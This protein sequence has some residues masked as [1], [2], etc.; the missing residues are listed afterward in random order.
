M[1]LNEFEML[2]ELAFR[3]RCGRFGGMTLEGGKS[4]GSPPPPDP[5]IAAAQKS[6]NAVTDQAWSNYQNVQAPAIQNAVN[7]Q[8]T[9]INNYANAMN[10]SAANQNAIAAQ[11]TG[12]YNNV[13]LPALQ[14]LQTA[15]NNYNTP[16]YQEE[17][18][19]SA[20][21][22][23]NQ[24]YAQQLKNTQ[25]Q[26]QAYGINPNSGAAQMAGNANAIQEASAGAAAATQARQQAINLGLNMQ[27][28]VFADANP[29]LANA[30]TAAQTAAGMQNSGLQAQQTNVNNV[31]NQSTLA[32]AA[33]QTATGGYGQSGQ[34]GVS[35]YNAQ[36]AAYNAQQQANA[37]A[38]AGL[39]GAIG[40][41]VGLYAGGAFGAGVGGAAAKAG[42]G[43]S[44]I[45]AKENIEFIGT[46][47]DGLNVYEFEYKPE[48][49]DD[50]M[51]G[52]GRFRG[53]MAHEVE[54]VY[55]HAVFTMDSGYKAVN[56]A[57][58]ANHG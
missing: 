7:T 33:A 8:A 30:N 48:F 54:R 25:L 39:Y 27:Q 1:R 29:S 34:L 51:A 45:R 28:N 24:Q 23:V 44:D 58:V 2:P 43:T 31:N 13:A 11:Q 40:T 5:S 20:L 47:P 41:G 37:T 55:P 21:G 32:N 53:L 16:G 26:Q 9:N 18:A 35:S 3:P 42:A 17:F 56:Y 10:T 52:H 46:R 50:P 14:N 22:D 49:K 4:S 36:I 57:E 38:T 12:I 19:S 15:A 6:I